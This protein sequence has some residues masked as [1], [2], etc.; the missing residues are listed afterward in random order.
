MKVKVLSIILTICMIVGLLP[1]L[2]LA[3][4][5]IPIKDPDEPIII[6][7]FNPGPEAGEVSGTDL[8]TQMEQQIPEVPED[9]LLPYE[10]TEEPLVLVE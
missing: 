2:A 10:K 7:P 4:T 8:L 5:I 6:K 9:A 1:T 3:E